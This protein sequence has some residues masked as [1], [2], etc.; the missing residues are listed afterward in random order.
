MA[1]W[2]GEPPTGASPQHL[3]FVLLLFL[4]MLDDCFSGSSVTGRPPTPRSGTA[5][6]WPWKYSGFAWLPGDKDASTAPDP[7]DLHS[8]VRVG[9]WRYADQ[10]YCVTTVQ[11]SSLPTWLCTVTV[12]DGALEGQPGEHV[13]SVRSTSKG[14][15]WSA[16][17]ALESNRSVVNAYSTVVLA[18]F[19]RVYA[20]YN[21]N[22]DGP[23]SK[24][25][26]GR[27]DTVGNFFMRYTDDFG[28]SWS[29]ERF[30]VPYRLTAVDR[31][32]SFPGRPELS[33]GTT[34]IMWTTDQT[35]VRDGV[36]YFGFTKIGTYPQG[37]PEEG[38]V[39]SS[40][41]ILTQRD[42]ARV[43]WKP[44]RKG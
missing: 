40:A 5:K 3:L 28:L 41:N 4:A 6:S 29:E 2:S 1:H 43:A 14:A 15:S 31:S 16:P 32:N 38:F 30:V 7:R 26:G 21:A 37:P 8:G 23:T 17:L 12:N 18:S 24:A 42:A 13:V 25:V 33:N 20:V 44:G 27:V 39:L 19:G 10:S 35:K 22:V 36:A 9:A 34:R 11:H